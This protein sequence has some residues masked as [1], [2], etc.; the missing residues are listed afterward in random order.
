MPDLEYMHEPEAFSALDQ[1]AVLVTV[2]RRLSRSLHCR[3]NELQ[4]SKGLTAWETPM[5]IPWSGWINSCLE[6]ASCLQPETEH[7]LRISMDQ[8]LILWEEIIR[9]SV[10]ARGILHLEETAGQARHARI[11]YSQWMLTR[12]VDQVLWST[13]EIEAFME[14]N[15]CLD[16]RLGENNWLE[17]AGQPEYVADLLEKEIISCP[18][19]FILAGFAQLSPVQ[20]HILDVLSRHGCPVYA[21]KLKEKKGFAKTVSMP[22][23]NREIKSAAL[24]IRKHLT[25]RTAESIGI[26]VP[27][28]SMIRGEIEHNFDA[29]LHPDKMT[30]PLPVQNRIFDLTLG[31]PLDSY[32][33]IAAAM[34]ILELADDPVDTRTLSAVLNS[35]FVPGAEFEAGARG[36]LD[37]V[38]RE[39][40]EHAAAWNRV[41]YF[42]GKNNSDSSEPCPFL[43]TCMQ[44]FK[45]KLSGL[46]SFQSPS[47]WSRTFDHLLDVFGWPG[48]RSLQS[49]EYQTLKAW[50]ECLRRLGTLDGFKKVFSIDQARSRLKYILQGTVFQP[51]SPEVQVRI[52]GM[53][54]AEG[55]TFDRLWIMGLTD[56]IWPPHADPSP[57][58]PASLQRRLNMP[59]SGP[60]Q[61]LAH[62][63]KILGRLL[64]SAEEVILSHPQREEDRE[65]QPSP[66]I[67]DIPVI[68]EDDLDLP[69]SPDPW[70]NRPLHE[71]LTS[72][73][74]DQ[75]PVLSDAVRAS[76]GSGVLKSQAL[77]PFQA[78]ARHRLGARNLEEPAIG[79]GTL[80][81]GT[82]IHSALEHFWRN[83]PDQAFLLALSPGELTCRVHDAAAQAVKNMQIRKGSS[84]T[85]EFIALEL[86]RVQNLLHEW[87]ELET[88]RAPF[89][90]YALEKP[91]KA[92]IN[93]LRL[94]VIADR[95]DR[96]ENGEMVIIDYKTGQPSVSEWFKDRPGEPQLP[97]YSLF[98]P[99]PV[100][101]VYF[102]LVRKGKC[103][104][105]GI[106]RHS[107]VIPGVM[108]F[109]ENRLARDYDSW[110]DLLD[111]W[112]RTLENLAGEYM[113]G[114]AG[115]DPVSPQ[116]C[117]LCDLG[118]LCRW[119]ELSAF[120]NF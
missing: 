31:K 74:D 82:I 89:Q 15:R 41:L 55:E 120:K 5:I 52:M 21:L 116:V 30:S 27:D 22:D 109:D 59:R 51:E 76:G 24:W 45:D 70:L 4:R 68:S 104:F 88:G 57:F 96:L 79:L 40:R 18:D 119:F 12:H 9:A 101:G 17:E 106:G 67:L 1:K 42:A 93:G 11:L 13:P 86:E 90:V 100:A 26:V 85:P 43:L 49:H 84:M 33:L 10:H 77:C 44:R 69:P 20:E 112:N 35:P 95:M 102:G 115:V 61:E 110:E 105:A 81:R 29:V 3:F 6:K 47:A 80:E 111:V 64:Q 117:R 19:L 72:F 114:F 118:P 56:Q 48:E 71:N 2:N 60:E 94:N 14:W 87:L 53:L 113:Q 34:N 38:L 37:A 108:G 32:P 91:I 78:F 28:L 103:C 75:G 65:L 54:E 98:C 36:R 8:E 25:N 63:R 23:R 62:A 66:L 58:L 39:G 99:E 107:D 7:P 83:C 92:E 46:P 73:H 50:H 97:I 16:E